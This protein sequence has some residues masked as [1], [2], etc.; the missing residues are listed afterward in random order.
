MVRI[1]FTNL[2]GY[3]DNGVSVAY[4]DNILFQRS[5]IADTLKS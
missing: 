4:I 3:A 2:G 1:G 5:Q